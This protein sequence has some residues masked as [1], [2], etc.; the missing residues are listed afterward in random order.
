MAVFEVGSVRYCVR[1][2]ETRRPDTVLNRARSRP[3]RHSWQSHGVESVEELQSVRVDQ[4]VVGGDVLSGP[5]QLD[6]MTKANFNCFARITFV[7]PPTV[8]Y[9]LNVTCPECHYATPST[10]I[11]LVGDGQV[12]C[13]QCGKKFRPLTGHPSSGASHASDPDID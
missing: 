1:G 7:M 11:S 2:G 13:S 9:D 3:L 12:V 6:C 4:I 10:D 5:M 8:I